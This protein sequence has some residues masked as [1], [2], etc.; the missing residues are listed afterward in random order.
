M[1]YRNVVTFNAM[2][3]GFLQNGRLSE[4]CRLFEDMPERNVVSWTAMFC[5]LAD[6]GRL[7]EA[8]RLF[9]EMP[10]RNVVSWNSMVV[11][12]IRNGE[13]EE[14]R[15][16]FD[17]MP[18][19]N[20]VSWNAMIGGYAESCRMREARDLFEEMEEKNVV[21]WTSMIAGYCRAGKVDEAYYLF[22][23]MPERNVVSWT[24]MIGGFAWNGLH[25]EALWL[26]REMMKNFNVRPN[27]E[28][29]ISL[30]YACAGMGYP[31]LGKQLHAQVI[32]DSSGNDDCDGRLFR[33][34][35]HMYSSFGIMDIAHYIHNTNAN[36]CTVQSCN[37]MINGYIHIGKL[38]EAQIFFDTM[39]FRD[40]ISWTSLIDGYLS[41][42][43]V[44]EACYLFNNM[45]DK[46]SVAWTAMI[47]GY[48]QNELFT[49]AISLFS[50]MLASEISPL[51]AT[52]SILFG[53]TGALA[54]IDL[55]RQLH[56]IM[57]KSQSELDLIVENS[58]ISMY[59]KC[60]LL[61]DAYY[62]FSNMKSRDLISWSSIIMGFSHHGLATETLKLFGSMLASGTHPNSLTFLGVLSACGHAGMVDKGW[63]LF[64]AMKDVYAI[65]PGLEHHISM[66]NLL[67]RA[68]KVKEAE[69]YVLRLPFEPD[70]HIWGALLGACGFGETNT[71]IA[72]YAAKRLLE[73]DPLNGPG[74]IV[75]C[76]IYAANGQ[77]LEEQKLRKEMGLKG[78]RKVPGCSWI[79]LSGKVHMFLS[80]DKVLPQVSDILSFMFIDF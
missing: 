58:L 65:Q 50:E 6:S 5:G 29:F 22:Q 41:A 76:N 17:V 23:A 64:N 53:A 78:V 44:L 14:A 35:I 45:P 15:R 49:E 57:L 74:H 39:P 18:V 72:E 27:G 43:K 54:N 52:F 13:L 75:L 60:G 9:E 68:G 2:L 24:A 38:E 46:D 26:F 34:L 32:V 37:E 56:C 33:S 1:P 63:Q 11:G 7:S 61:D 16:I 47:S 31:K 79:I 30:A 71:E 51:T 70:H 8:K 80:G 12:L 10:E 3:S 19:K 36:L 40:K 42:G 48:V 66:I 20:V 73:L 67:G 59:A 77:H 28:T 69:E 21:T 55:G 62:I 25:E 4:A